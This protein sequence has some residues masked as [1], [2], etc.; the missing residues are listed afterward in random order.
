MKT[1]V[2]KTL[3]AVAALTLGTQSFAAEGTTNVRFNMP[4]IVVLHYVSNVTFEIDPAVFGFNAVT[5]YSIE[6]NSMRT[7]L[8]LTANNAAVAV[9]SNPISGIYPGMIENAWAV[10]SMTTL[11]VDVTIDITGTETALNGTSE[12]T[13][14]LPTLHSTGATGTGTNAIHFSSQG[15]GTPVYGDVG[16]GINFDLTTE[17]GMHT[18]AQYTI[19]A[20]ATL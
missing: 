12:V 3:T 14:S 10:R 4:S 20:L 13:I 17:A 7:F 6:D 19:E 15:M 2:K 11:G 18:G 1:L 5:D 16:F 8:T 9:G